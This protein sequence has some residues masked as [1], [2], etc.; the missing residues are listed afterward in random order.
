ME[1]TFELLDPTLDAQHHA[2]ALSTNRPNEIP[3]F[4]LRT[5][6][7]AWRLHEQWI[8]GTLLRY[9]VMFSVSVSVITIWKSNLCICRLERAGL[10]PL[11]RMIAATGDEVE[12]VQVG[13]A[14]NITSN[15]HGGSPST[16]AFWVLWSICGDQRCTPST[17]RSVRWR[18][19]WRTWP[20]LLGYRSTVPLSPPPYLLSGGRTRSWRGS[21]TS[22][23][24]SRWEGTL[25]FH[26]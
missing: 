25:P 3:V 19:H 14:R 2:R 22:Y 20:C 1:P 8:L 9:V 5:P 16:T 12:N 15:V 24:R 10:L 17:C 21:R 23:R 18:W 6:Q 11:A 26:L 4:Q 7:S 13:R